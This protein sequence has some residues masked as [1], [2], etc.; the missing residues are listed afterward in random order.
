MAKPTKKQFD[1]VLMVV[2]L[3]NVALVLPQMWA[4]RKLADPNTSK[5]VN[6][7]A[8]FVSLT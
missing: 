4:A 3:G 2:I 8:G 1:L 5:P 7:F 6:D